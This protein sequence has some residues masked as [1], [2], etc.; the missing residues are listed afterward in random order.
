MSKLPCNILK[1][2]GG[3]NAPPRLRAWLYSS[4]PTPESPETLR[5]IFKKRQKQKPTKNQN[6]KYRNTSWQGGPNKTVWAASTTAF[7]AEQLRNSTLNVW[8]TRIFVCE[9]QNEI[10]HTI[11]SNWWRN[12]TIRVFP[13]ILFGRPGNEK[14]QKFPGILETGIAVS[15]PYTQPQKLCGCHLWRLQ[16]DIFDTAKKFWLVFLRRTRNVWSVVN[17]APT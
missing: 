8:P 17:F 9:V 5:K 13:G 14:S 4:V 11:F 12:D 2:F 15:K 16:V 3:E 7:A 10:F 1:I 6:T